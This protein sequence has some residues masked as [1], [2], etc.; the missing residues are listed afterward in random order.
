MRMWIK[1]FGA[2]VVLVGL[3]LIFDGERIIKEHFS[4]MGNEN[5]SIFGIK[6]LGTLVAIL[7]GIVVIL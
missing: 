2:V 4:K 6:A 1:I 5:N 7:G 3:L